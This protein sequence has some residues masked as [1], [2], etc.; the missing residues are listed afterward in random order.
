MEF[1]PQ[2]NTYFCANSIQVSV[3]VYGIH[4][5]YFFQTR[6]NMHISTNEHTHA[7]CFDGVSFLCCSFSDFQLQRFTT[8]KK[9]AKGDLVLKILGFKTDTEKKQKHR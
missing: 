6:Q 1:R 2:K 5:W 8:W 9:A 4:R 7:M 3:W